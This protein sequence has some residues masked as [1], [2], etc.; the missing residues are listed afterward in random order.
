MN[1]RW[2]WLVLIIPAVIGLARLRF[3]VEVLNLLPDELPVVHGLK[4]YQK[5]FTS[6][7]ELVITLRASDA[8]TAESA[9]RL[10]AEFLRRETNLVANAVWRAP[11]QENP[12][13][14][15]ELTAYLWLNQPTET[16]AQFTNR[17]APDKLAAVLRETR[18]QLV[19]TLS[20][21]DLA[22]LGYDP[23]GLTRLPGSD[24]SG[25]LEFGGQ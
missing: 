22:R 24:L 18:E 25:G 20:P 16:F 9:A 13:Q 10:L 1:R 3:D 17:F 19:T 2:W 7:D 11:W 8:E 6:G 14:M 4:L 15:A 21:T 23:F 5:H 12:D